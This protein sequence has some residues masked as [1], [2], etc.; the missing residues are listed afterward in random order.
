MRRIMERLKLVVNESK[1][2]LSCVPDEHFDFLGYTLGRYYSTK[3][4]RAFI[5][6]APSRKRIERIYRK[7]H[8]QTDRRWLLQEAEEMTTR[9]NRMLIGWSQYF[10]LGAVSKAYRAVDAHV[11]YRLRQWLC[12]KHKKTGR[13]TKRYPDSYLYKQLGLVCLAPRTHNFPWAKA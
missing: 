12:A 4:G 2:H 3:T 1:T 13:G 5:G 7:I 6:T 9:L 8:E 10:C 11:R